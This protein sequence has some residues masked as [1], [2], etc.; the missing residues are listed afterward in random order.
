MDKLDKFI[1]ICAEDSKVPV[2]ERLERAGF[3]GA[4][5]DAILSDPSAL[6]RALQVGINRYFIPIVPALCKALAQ[7]AVGGDKAALINVMA[8]LGDKSPL[9]EA[10]GMDMA[11]ASDDALLSRASQLSKQ[12]TTL[13]EASGARKEKKT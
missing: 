2:F 13:I 4:A 9:K 7:R 11:S 1:E 8:F 5:L 12:L 10:G 3:S 6:Q